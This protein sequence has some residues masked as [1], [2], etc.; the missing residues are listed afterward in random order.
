MEQQSKLMADHEEQQATTMLILNKL[1]QRE[2]T[3]PAK[4][5]ARKEN[6]VLEE[7]IHGSSAQTNSVEAAVG[8]NSGKGKKNKEP[9]LEDILASNEPDI[10]VHVS[11]HNAT[12][13]QEEIDLFDQL[14]NPRNPDQRRLMRERRTLLQSSPR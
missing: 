14:Q 1:L 6:P 8:S 13:L 7:A 2:A 11:E 3:E 9:G 12:Y 5:K 4:K 10:T